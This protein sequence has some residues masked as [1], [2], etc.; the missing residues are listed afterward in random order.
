MIR[1]SIN[2][3][4]EF[5]E[6]KFRRFNLRELYKIIF[7]SFV[8]S[9]YHL[10]EFDKIARIKSSLPRM[11]SLN[12]RIIFDAFYEGLKFTRAFINSLDFN[13][14]RSDGD[15][16]DVKQVIK[17]LKKRLPEVNSV[18][19]IDCLSPIELITLYI[20]LKHQGIDADIPE[21]YFVN[22]AGLTS[23]LTRQVGRNGTV[24]KFS[25]LLKDNFGA[26]Y[27]EPYSYFDKLVHD[28]TIILIKDFMKKVPIEDFF[29]K[30]V[31][32][33]NNYG[34]LLLTSDH[35][36]NVIDQSDILYVTHPAEDGVLRFCNFALYLIVWK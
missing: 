29:N 23:F 33:I 14:L 32:L 20:E 10:R 25:K 31:E 28:A 13:P 35:G 15:Y 11:I 9:G 18:Y 8:R 34:S 3:I 19:V 24:R 21:I 7:S 36:Y 16:S 12:Q 17:L 22:R 27:N 1:E 2:E 4:Y 26:Q 6:N 30:I 5:I